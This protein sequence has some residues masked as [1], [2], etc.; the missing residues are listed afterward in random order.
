[1][2]KVRFVTFLCLAPFS[3]WAKGSPAA[4]SLLIGVGAPAIGMGQAYTAVA[5]DASAL[6]WNPASMAL[7]EHFSAVMNHAA[8]VDS[9]FK[10]DAAVVQ[11]LGPLGAIGV[12]GQYFTVGSI[13]RLDGAGASL[14]SFQP[15]DGAVLAGYALPL[16]GASVGVSGKMIRSKVGDVAKTQAVD[17]GI[18][19]PMFD[20]NVRLAGA[21]ANVGKGLKYGSDGAREDLPEIVRAGASFR[22]FGKSLLVS[23]EGGFPAK[24]D[25]YVAAGVEYSKMVYYTGENDKG[26]L[27]SGRLGYNTINKGLNGLAGPSIGLGFMMQNGMAFDYAFL[28]MGDLGVTHHLTF[29]YKI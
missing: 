2:T 28:P 20:R 11:T 7:V 1:M 15:Y 18:Q 26:I 10:D 17:A 27:V 21:V 6:F 25:A 29:S 14:G 3:L 22:F 9:G 24:E 4:D 8:L 16:G 12:G 19:I 5:D 23:A 13:Q